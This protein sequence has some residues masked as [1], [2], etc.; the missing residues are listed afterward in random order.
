[1]VRRERGLNA[2]A[3]ANFTLDPDGRI[4]EVRMEPIP[5]L[6]DF[7]FDFQGLRLTPV[8]APVK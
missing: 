7:S 5:T 4:R 8:D 2:G 3:F 6:T 1:M